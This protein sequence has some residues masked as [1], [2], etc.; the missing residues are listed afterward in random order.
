MLAFAFAAF[1]RYE[2]YRAK[3][4]SVNRSGELVCSIAI[5]EYDDVYFLME[6]DNYYYIM[7]VVDANGIYSIGSNVV[8]AV[9]TIP[10][11]S[12]PFYDDMEGGT[13]NWDWNLPWD[14]TTENS[15]SGSNSWSDSPS[16]GY[17]NSV[18]I[19]IETSIDLSVAVMP[20]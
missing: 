11:V 4:P 12:Y 5:T 17:D 18:N 14:I 6:P 20:G 8:K 2:I 16:G 15:H 19:V 1:D 9:Y 13:G 10:K 3:N 7:Y